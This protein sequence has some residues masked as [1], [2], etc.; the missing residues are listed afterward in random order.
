[1]AKKKTKLAQADNDSQF[2][3]KLVVFTII[4]CQWIFIVN[5]E[6]TSQVPL[7]VGLIVGLVLA[8]QDHFKTNRKIE[9]ALLLIVAVVGFWIRSG[10]EIV[11]L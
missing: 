1:M 7:P 2:L 4:G 9:Y 3:L 5:P 8:G 6:G 11:G 10:I